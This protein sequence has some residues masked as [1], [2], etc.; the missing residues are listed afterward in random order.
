MYKQTERS[1]SAEQ[2]FV[3]NERMEM[4]GSQLTKLSANDMADYHGG[5]IIVEAKTNG[6]L[7]GMGIGA[8]IGFMIGGPAGALEGAFWGGLLWLLLP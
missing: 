8:A 1:R 6:A 2:F 4:G 5:N 3:P 7:I